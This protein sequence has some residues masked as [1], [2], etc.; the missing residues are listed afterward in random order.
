[1]RHLDVLVLILAGLLMLAGP[2]MALQELAKARDLEARG[3]V[4]DPAAAPTDLDLGFR[5]A[6][7]SAILVLTLAL[8]VAGCVVMLRI[9][10]QPRVRA[11]SGRLLDRKS[12]V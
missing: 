5:L 8:D 1:M 11:A 3:A 4:I 7:R 10:R 2:I 9:G 6:W 12:V